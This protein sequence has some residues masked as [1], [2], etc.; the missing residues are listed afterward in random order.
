MQKDLES[1]L[2][3]L[4]VSIEDKD[5]EEILYIVRTR[6][7]KTR[8]SYY[9]YNCE[10]KELKFLA[11]IS[12]WLKAEEMAEMKPIQYKSRD[13]LTIHGYLT[14]PNGKENEKN[15][16]V[17]INPHGGPWWRDSWGFNPEIQFL[18]NRGY[19]VLQM[20]FRSSTGYGRK[21]WEAGFKQWGLKMQDDITDGVNWLIE[22]G[23]ADP[24]RIAIYGG[25]YGGYATLAGITF[26]PELY[27]CA[28]DYVGVSNLFTFFETFPP[29]WEQQRKIMEEKVGNPERRRQKDSG[30]PHSRTCG[31]QCHSREFYPHPVHTGGRATE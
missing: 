28:V 24:K 8:G 17:V 6:S 12:P 29:Y 4:E 11:E 3:N 20:N 22:Q 13:G 23:I 1:K 16:P 7:D 31:C 2:P 30:I 19:A 9:I 25:S 18:A 5:D 27:S 10:T 26:T 21:F 15:L 14:M